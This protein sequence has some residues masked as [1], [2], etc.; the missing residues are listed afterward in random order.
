MMNDRGICVCVHVC[1]CVCVCV[2]VF[3]TTTYICTI[4]RVMAN[5][6]TLQHDQWDEGVQM[7]YAAQKETYTNVH[8]AT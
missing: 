8:R 7:C 4:D 2:C 5:I 3:V 1:V 6:Q